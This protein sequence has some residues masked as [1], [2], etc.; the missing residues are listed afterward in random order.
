MNP[1]SISP[2]RLVPHDGAIRV[3]LRRALFDPQPART[4]DPQVMVV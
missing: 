1:S 4:I 2:S 3:V